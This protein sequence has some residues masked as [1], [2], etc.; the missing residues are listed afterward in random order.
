ML[1]NAGNA[2]VDGVVVAAVVLGPLL[3]VVI[4]VL[5]LRHARRHDAEVAAQAATR[6]T[7]GRRSA[8]NGDLPT[9]STR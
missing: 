6:N 2:T 3:A 5:G 8:G 1:G 4:F 7:Q 9:R